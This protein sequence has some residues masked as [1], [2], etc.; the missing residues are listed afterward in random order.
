[1]KP[2]ENLFLI[3]P[4]ASGKTSVAR[5]LS[6]KLGLG[7]KDT[8]EIV[9]AK[10]GTSI[11]EFVDGH[12]WKAFRRLERLALAEAAEQGGSVIATGGGIVLDE[13]NVAL[14][15]S[16]GPVF[17]LKADPDTL[18]GRLAADPNEEQRP[19]LTG[20][21]LAGEV[22]QVLAEREPLYRGCADHVVQSSGGPESAADEIMR[23]IE[24]QGE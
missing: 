8:D 15:K 18:A 22:A 13:A 16:G 2:G 19:S 4:R 6:A 17:Y 11:A 5:I 23:L 7:M 1:M 12:G 21:D 10:I 24:E 20:G 3:G 9:S 14:L